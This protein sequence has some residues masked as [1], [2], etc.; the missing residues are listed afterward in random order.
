MLEYSVLLNNGSAVYKLEKPN[1]LFHIILESTVLLTLSVMLNQLMTINIL[2]SIEDSLSFG[3]KGM[4]KNETRKF[5]FD[6]GYKLRL[7]P[8]LYSGVPLVSESDPIAILIT[9]VH[10]TEPE[11]YKI[12]SHLI[13]GNISAVIDMINEHRG[14]NAVDE[15]GEVNDPTLYLSFPMIISAH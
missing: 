6:S 10:I 8:L 13:E 15:W 11:D 9:V 12:F 1:Q 5:I 14:V 7:P 2:Q 3:M 4:C